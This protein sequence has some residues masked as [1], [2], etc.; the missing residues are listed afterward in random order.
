MLQQLESFLAA[1]TTNA[2]C[3]SIFAMLLAT[4]KK[5]VLLLMINNKLSK[6]VVKMSVNLSNAPRPIIPKARSD[7]YSFLDFDALEISRQ[8]T[9]LTHALFC[10]INARELIDSN[11]LK[12]SSDEK[13]PNLL[14]LLS[15]ERSI[16][17]W[18]ITEIISERNPKLQI[19]VLEKVIHISQVCY[20]SVY[21]SAFRETI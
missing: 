3:G 15:W 6:E 7:D 21:T 12:D 8:L 19:Q 10:K 9:L 4:L 13:S 1:N 5:S 17:N 2:Y 11:W 20:I 16:E 14:N 18:L